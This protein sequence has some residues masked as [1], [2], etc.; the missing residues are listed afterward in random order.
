ML[1]CE[2]TVLIIMKNKIEYSKIDAAR[3]QIN[4]AIKLFFHDECPISV[5]T[6]TSTSYNILYDISKNSNSNFHFEMDVYIKPEH[7]KTWKYKVNE[8]SNF[9]KHADRDPNAKIEFEE[10]TNELRLFNCCWGYCDLTKEFTP[11]MSVF[12]GWMKLFYSDLFKLED[13]E[14]NKIMEGFEMYNIDPQNRKTS[15]EAGRL[16]LKN[17]GLLE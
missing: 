16:L 13:N 5:H 3:A 2:K 11:Y 1:W 15:L 7:L 10:A 8:A 6:L 12:M 17:Q 4:T 9:F 14:L